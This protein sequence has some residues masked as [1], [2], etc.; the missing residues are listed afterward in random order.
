[1][2]VNFI[3]LIQEIRRVG[4]SDTMARLRRA[5]SGP[6]LVSDSGDDAPDPAPDHGEQ[7][8][9]NIFDSNQKIY[10]SL[11]WAIGVALVWFLM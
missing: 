1:M 10:V 8:P 3:Y 5:L 4:V 9:E 7:V 2:C 11:M 6:G